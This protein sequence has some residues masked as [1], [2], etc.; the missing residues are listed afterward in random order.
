MQEMSEERLSAG[1]DRGI[2]LL[3]TNIL[4]HSILGAWLGAAAELYLPT[5]LPSQAPSIQ[6]I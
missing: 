2:V 5:Y 1:G 6:T 4:L 3:H